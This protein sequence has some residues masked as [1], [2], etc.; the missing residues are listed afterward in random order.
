MQGII[1]ILIPC[2]F[3]TCISCTSINEDPTYDAAPRIELIEMR[4]D[5]VQ[6]FRDSL[7]FIVYYEDGDGDLGF[8][9]FDSNSVFIRDL[10]FTR[11][12]E[13]YLGPITPEDITESI[14]GQLELIL[15]DLFVL[16]SQNFEIT[17]FEIQI[18]DRSGNFSNLIESGRVV[19]KK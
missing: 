19:I 15:P 10:R 1:R 18:K 9:N 17:S 5:T 4:P 13:Y 3:L 11:F 12:D 2:L 16:S 7:T 6:E 14:N 8:S